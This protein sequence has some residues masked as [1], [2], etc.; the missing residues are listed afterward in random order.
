MNENM[1][2][3][4]GMGAM[5]DQVI[6]T[7]FLLSAK[8]GV[9]NLAVAVTEAS[10]PEVREALKQYLN[11]AVETHERISNYMVEKGYYH[12]D[13]LKE[14]LNVDLQAARTAMNLHQQ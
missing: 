13:N 2:N 5:T 14:Q 8:T 10:T 1:Q 12:P 4:S 7:D 3:S 11:D 9:K 6:A